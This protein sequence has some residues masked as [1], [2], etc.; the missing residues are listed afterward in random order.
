[1]FLQKAV[2]WQ[3]IASNANYFAAAS[4]TRDVGLSTAEIIDYLIS[5]R[6]V[7]PK[8]I[9]IIGHS[10]GAHA[11]GYAGSFIKMGRVGRIT[12]ML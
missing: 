3:A 7:D 6:D 12:G 9:Q 10:L 11:A 5:E 4:Q 2:D 8:T 1:M